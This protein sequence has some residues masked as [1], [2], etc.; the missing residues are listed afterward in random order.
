MDGLAKWL[1]DVSWPIVSRVLVA[2][3]FGTVTYNGLSTA[4]DG[5]VDAA[6]TAVGGLLPTIAQLF[7]LG[8]FFD[9]MAITAGGVISGLGYLVLKH[10][11]LKAGTT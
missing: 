8:G 5:V 6:K 11:A 2:M 3:G 1:S 4:F 7:A 10:F 9:H